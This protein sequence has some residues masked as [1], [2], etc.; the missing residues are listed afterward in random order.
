MSESKADPTVNV[1]QPP[2]A[3]EVEI[4]P[5]VVQPTSPSTQ[6]DHGVTEEVHEPQEEPLPTGVAQDSTHAFIFYHASQA[7]AV[8]RTIVRQNEAG[9]HA[10]AGLSAQQMTAAFLIALGT[11]IG[12][13]VLGHL[14]RG[15]VHAITAGL[16]QLPEVG[17][18]TGLQALEMVRQRIVNGEYAELGG[19][20]FARDLLTQV[21]GPYGTNQVLDEVLSPAVSGF[22]LLA[23]ARP[24]QVVPFITSEHPQTIALILSQLNVTVAAGI[25]NHLSERLQ[26]DVAYRMAT[27]GNITAAALTR[28]E[29]RLKQT[30]RE[31]IGGVHTVG[32]PKVLADILNLSESGTEKNVLDQMDAQDPQVAEDVRQRMFVFDDIKTMFDHDIQKLLAQVDQRDLAICLK[33]ASESLKDRILDNMSEQARASI[34]EQ[35]EFLGPMHLSAVEAVQLGI[36]QQLR[37]LEAQGEVTILRGDTANQFV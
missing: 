21:L 16:V 20:G 3:A 22:A 28:V 36:V 31:L 25:L 19:E 26:A 12:S 8:L 32:G 10:L 24:E 6:E 27:M 1:W 33:A 29:D 11:E 15:E 9:E 37:Q 23:Q 13:R 4:V 2:L 7:A 17:H 30:L 18:N 5:L 35:M 14:D 34:T